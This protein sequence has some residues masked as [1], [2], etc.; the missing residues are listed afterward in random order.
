M[1]SHITVILISTLEGR[2]NKPNQN[3]KARK[4]ISILCH[5]PR[6]MNSPSTA[7]IWGKASPRIR[8]RTMLSTRVSY[9]PHYSATNLIVSFML[10]LPCISLQVLLN[11]GIC[12]LSI[13]YTIYCS[14][15]HEC[16]NC[17]Q[18]EVVTC[19]APHIVEGLLSEDTDT[20]MPEFREK[21]QRYYGIRKEEL[22]R[23]R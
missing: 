4:R 17:L 3:N 7:M 18:F 11:H 6:P 16:L 5:L 21:I 22:E 12:S 2:I 20:S 10:T 13:W 15:K 23:L 8:Q 19:L 1:F 14:S 9:R